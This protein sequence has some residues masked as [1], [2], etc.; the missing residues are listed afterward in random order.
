MNSNTYATVELLRRR[1][2]GVTPAIKEYKSRT[3]MP[4]QLSKYHALGNDYLIG[5]DADCRALDTRMVRRLCHRNLGVGSDGLLVYAPIGDGAFRVRI[6]NPD[7]SEAEKSGNGLRILARHLWDRKLVGDA[8]FAVVTAGGR[9]RA[10][11]LDDGRRVTVDM[12]RAVFEPSAIPV[13]VD[14]PRAIDVPLVVAGRELR[15]NAVSMGN[16][17]CVVLLDDISEALARE[18]GPVLE[19]HEL[20]PNRTNVQLVKVLGPEDLAIEIWERGAGYTLASGTSSCAVVSVA[21]L[22]G[23]CGRSVRVHS[24]GGVVAVEI[25]DDDDLRMTGA[26]QRIATIE[27]DDECFAAD[28]G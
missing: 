20:F 24:P 3:T 12:G 17:H 28:G 10:R 6:L 1:I 23:L 18:I 21:H 4:L 14:G 11:V 16:P 9:V 15:I 19:A 13:R 8:A 7:G 22:R 25:G 5:S 27:V 2:T 26:V